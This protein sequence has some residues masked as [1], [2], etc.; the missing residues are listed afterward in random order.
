MELL[1]LMEEAATASGAARF[2]PEVPLPVVSFQEMAAG[3]PRPGRR[4]DKGAL[5]QFT[6]GSTSQP[7]GVILSLDAILA[8]I[9]SLMEVLPP[10]PDDVVCSWLPLSHDM[11][12]I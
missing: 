12:L 9:L 4:N 3:G 6:S 10:R 7:K 2:V 1:G 8:N 11:G 5:V